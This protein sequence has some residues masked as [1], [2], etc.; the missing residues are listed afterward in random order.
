MGLISHVLKLIGGFP[1][2]PIDIGSGPIGE[3]NEV[4][5]IKLLRKPIAYFWSSIKPVKWRGDINILTVEGCFC[6]GLFYINASTGRILP[7]GF[8][9]KKTSKMIKTPEYGPKDL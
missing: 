2:I 3:P 1:L 4:R 6:T 8:E 7:S 9:I 5:N